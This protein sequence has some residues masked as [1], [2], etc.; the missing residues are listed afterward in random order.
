MSAADSL[1]V[2]AQ[3]LAR[4]QTISK[5]RKGS[6]EEEKAVSRSST[7]SSN[8]STEASRSPA[9]SEASETNAEWEPAAAS[10]P[11]GEHD[12]PVMEGCTDQ[13]LFRAGAWVQGAAR[14]ALGHGD[15]VEISHLSKGSLYLI[16]IPLAPGAELVSSVLGT[17]GM[18]PLYHMRVVL[19][20]QKYCYMYEFGSM[21]FHATTILNLNR[22]RTYSNMSSRE[23]S[24][25][26]LQAWEG[27]FMK[28][29]VVKA[30]EEA[31]CKTGEYC[32]LTNNCQ[33]FAGG[34]LKLL[35]GE[36]IAAISWK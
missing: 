9:R 8:A 16:A 28:A 21:G 3:V 31:R 34:M 33:H 13:L 15:H 19:M 10:G 5:G 18:Q 20:L 1:L 6:Y 2:A 17:F 22:A 32:M 12:L 24:G 36:D 35:T 23:G 4:A 11:P 7:V 25:F 14:E 27:P 29:T 26:V 30:Y